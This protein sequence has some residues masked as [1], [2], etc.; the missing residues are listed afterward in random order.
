MTI[1]ISRRGLFIGSFIISLAGCQ[2]LSVDPT[3]STDQLVPAEPA[4]AESSE[5]ETALASALIDQVQPAAPIDHPSVEVTSPAEPVEQPA[6]ADLWQL[7]RDN[8]RLDHNIDDRRVTAQVNWYAGHPRYLDRVAQRAERYYYHV[9]HQVL[10]RGLPAELALLP[11]VESAFDPFAYSHGRAA[12]PWQFIPSTGK[13]FGLKQT[14]WYDGRRDVI[15]STEAALDYLTQLNQRFDGDWLLALAAYNAG[16]GN[17]SKA[18]RKNKKRGKPTDFW[19]LDLPRETSAYVPKLIALAKLIDDPAAYQ[20]SFRSLPNEPYFAAIDVG[21]QI[22]LAKAAE[23]AELEIDELYLLNPGFN[24]WATDP[25]GPHRLLVPVANADIF[26]AAL[27]EYPPEKRVTWKRYKVKSGDSL[28]TI[29]KKHHTTPDTLRSANSIRGNMIRAGQVL[30][31]PTASES[32]TVYAY[33]KGQRQ[34]KKNE[35][36]ALRS[37][38]QKLDYYVR[39][40][41]SF[42]KIAREYGVGVRELASWNQMAPGDPLRVGR[43]LVVWQPQGELV[44]SNGSRQVIRKVGY[45]VRNG[46]SLARIASRFKVR[47][48]DIKRWNNEVA[49]AKYL[50]PGQQLT[51][52]VDVTGSR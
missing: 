52:F 14:W 31:I 10:E 43:K 35:R 29:A 41:D 38:K 7:T 47:V 17:V 40:G 2:A 44:A 11:I 19:N 33:S 39:P 42:W 18:I 6:P 25:K 1:K 46:D 34:A 24:Q 37:G 36:I 32:A 12:G 27:A 5:T 45:T 21:S 28:I 48:S 30:L 49:S 15:A 26:E 16:G 51:L 20:L 23:L 22:D 9:L 4:S 13:H 8:F 3:R 50:Q